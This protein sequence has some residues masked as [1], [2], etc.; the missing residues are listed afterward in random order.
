MLQS[1][2][3]IFPNGGFMPGEKE[4]S[5]D[6][7]DLQVNLI[8]LCPQEK[9]LRLSSPT[10][11]MPVIL[12]PRC[13]ICGNV[14]V[15]KRTRLDGKTFRLMTGLA[16]PSRQPSHPVKGSWLRDFSRHGA[17]DRRSRVSLTKQPWPGQ[18]TDRCPASAAATADPGSA[19]HSTP[20]A[21]LPWPKP[22][23][24]SEPRCCARPHE[25]DRWS[26]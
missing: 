6:L 14:S 4:R 17:K 23:I 10:M 5:G 7:L 22:S 24:L 13:L 26:G 19:W 2:G 9:P 21:P 15:S 11:K 1:S 12:L 20:D 8:H 25:Y 3:C 18:G 16:T